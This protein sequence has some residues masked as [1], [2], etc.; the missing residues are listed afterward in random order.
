VD[1]PVPAPGAARSRTR[2][3]ALLALAPV[4][5]LALL[6]AVLVASARDTT[7]A[8]PTTVAADSGSPAG[9]GAG[10]P[11]GAG[12]ASGL[13]AEA[14]GDAITGFELPDL[15][16]PG[17]TI[18]FGNPT[19]PTVVNFFAAWCGP[20]RQEMPLIAKASHGTPGVDFLGVNVQDVR[21][22]AL[23]M[24]AAFGVDFPAAVDSDRSLV[25]QWHLRGMPTTLFIAP[26]GRVVAEHKGALAQRD[27]TRLLAQLE[28]E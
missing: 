23:A 6:V 22:E 10:S 5:A 7:S 19:R 11:A 28:G 27:M 4:A 15:R 8:R 16:H 26:G 17:G 14:S 3:T 1:G 25:R 24:L 12:A 18:R 20:C 21:S 13:A 9:A 2:R